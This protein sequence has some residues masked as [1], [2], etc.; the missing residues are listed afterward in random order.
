MPDRKYLQIT[1]LTKDL[2]SDIKNSENSVIKKNKQKRQNIFKDI[3]PEDIQ[4]ANKSTHE[5][6]LVSLVI[7]EI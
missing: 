4:K 6:N 3:L 5:R 2:Y 1:N 7:R